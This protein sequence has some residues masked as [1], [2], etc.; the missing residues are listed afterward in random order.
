MASQ[1]IGFKKPQIDHPAFVC[2]V[3]YRPVIPT[4]VREGNKMAQD[5]TTRRDRLL[6]LPEVQKLTGLG[7]TFIYQ[8]T[9]N[10]TV[11]LGRASA[12]PESEVLAWVEARKAERTAA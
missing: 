11:K 10:K 8:A 7:R 12:W 2:L 3:R 5:Q 9:A 1:R 4:T 6:R